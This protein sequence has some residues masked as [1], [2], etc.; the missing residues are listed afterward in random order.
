[1]VKSARINIPD[2]LYDAK[3]KAARKG[4]LVQLSPIT[5]F[6]RILRFFIQHSVQQVN[7]LSIQVI[8]PQYNHYYLN[9]RRKS[10]NSFLWHFVYSSISKHP[11]LSF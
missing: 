6:S 9:F 2:F 3:A 11:V 5:S 8:L 4:Y 7:A 10:K 1:M